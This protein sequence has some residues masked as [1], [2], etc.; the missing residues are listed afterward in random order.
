MQKLIMEMAERIDANRKHL[1]ERLKSEL[2]FAEFLYQ[3]INKKDEIKYKKLLN[4]AEQFLTESFKEAHSNID[5]IVNKF[6]ELMLPFST[7][8]KEYTIYCIGHAHIDMNWMWSWPETVAVTNDTFKTVLALL[9]EYPDFCF[10]QSQASVYKIIEKYN[11]VLLDKI[12]KYV[13]EGRWELTASHWVEN[14]A[15]IISGEAMCRHLLYT[16]K[17]MKEIFGVKPEDIPVNWAPD[18]FGFAETVPSILRQGAI[19]YMYLHRPGTLRL[20]K[21]TAFYWKAKDGAKVLVKNDMHMG[22]NCRIGPHIVTDYLVN[23][24]KETGLKFVNV[25]YGIGDHGGG[26]TKHDLNYALEM[27]QWKIFPNIKFATVREF[28]ERLEL[29]G[30]K[31]PVIEGELNFEFTGCYTSQSIIKRI[32]RYGEKRLL[33]TE[34]ESTF[35][36][37]ISGK[38]P[39]LPIMEQNWQNILFSHFH[40]ILPGSGVH[41]TRTYIHGLYQETMASAGIIAT[42]ALSAIAENVNTILKEQNNN[43]DLLPILIKHSSF[44]GGAGYGTGEGGITAAYRGEENITHFLVFNTSAQSRY[45]V[46]EFIIWANSNN[47]NLKNIKFKAVSPNGKFIPCQTTEVGSYWG[48]D[49]VKIVFPVDLPSN[50]YALYS[51]VEGECDNNV[52]SVATQI[53]LKHHCFYAFYEKG[54][55]GIENEYIRLELNPKTGWINNLIPKKFG[56][57]IVSNNHL[58]LIEYSEERVHNMTAWEV[59][60]SSNFLSPELRSIKRLQDGPY[61]AMIEMS[62]SIK[63]SDLKVKYEL[64]A[65]D[66]KLYI[67]LDI[68]WFQRGTIK[69]GVPRLDFV[70]P[71]F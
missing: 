21:P 11:P 9:A 15:N 28:F 56:K 2:E 64:R 65:G 61:K 4:A 35:A 71:V 8:A 58:P 31:L 57:S 39:S 30:K 14:D 25:V 6:E 24:V 10:S 60:Y 3:R 29:E 59:D 54:P 66:P 47:K 48:H 70:L 1:I 45:E 34:Q 17:Y 7:L 13:K 12:K 67:T 49:F 50:G 55:E 46:L 43:E 69:D 42:E 44:G 38:R 33:D 52:N 53:G 32:A 22:Y 26:P 37:F 40:D 27:N 62:F 20:Q 18:T 5:V 23:F 19:K 63:E 36:Y 16:R 51:V 68:T 41:D